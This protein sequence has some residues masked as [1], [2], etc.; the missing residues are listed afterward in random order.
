M[1]IVG[2]KYRHRLIDYPPET[3]TR[4]TMDKVREALMSAIGENIKGRKVLDLFAGSGALGIESLSRGAEDCLFVDSNSFATETIA[5]NIR[6]VGVEEK[7]RIER[8]DAIAFLKEERSE[9]FSLVFLDPPYKNKEIYS[10]CI[11]LLKERNLLAEDAILVVESEEEREEDPYFEKFR[12]YRY[13]RIHI[14]IY[15]RKL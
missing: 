15:W 13:G 10:T 14:G 6:A 9:T 1:R 4:P 3:I 12:R 8:K 5:R 11:E 2:G 7:T